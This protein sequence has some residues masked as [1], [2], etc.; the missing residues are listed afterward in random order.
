M[1]NRTVTALEL[2]AMVYPGV[3]FL[4]SI[5]KFQCWPA[6]YESASKAFEAEPQ[7]CIFVDCR[8]NSFWRLSADIPMTFEHVECRRVCYYEWYS[9]EKEK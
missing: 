4:D 7:A 3:V 1:K 2:A 6:T 5:Y 9:V 8:D